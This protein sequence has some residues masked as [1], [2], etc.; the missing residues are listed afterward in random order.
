MLSRMTA[1]PKAWSVL[2]T[3]IEFAAIDKMTHLSLVCAHL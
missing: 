2:V 3:K 1:I